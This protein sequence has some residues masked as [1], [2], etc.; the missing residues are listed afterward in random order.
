M[1][2]SITHEENLFANEDCVIQLK[3]LSK[4]RW[5][6]T[7]DCFFQTTIL[8]NYY[9][10]ML[11]TD[12]FVPVMAC[13]AVLLVSNLV[14]FYLQTWPASF[15]VISCQ[16]QLNPAQAVS[17]ISKNAHLQTLLG[18]LRLILPR[19]DWNILIRSAYRRCKACSRTINC[20]K[21]E[22]LPVS[23]QR[24]LIAHC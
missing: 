15:V 7:W 2:S 3:D 20:N 24:W 6:L 13:Y 14:A 18:I 12:A 16:V 11:L 8:K 1:K 5:T 9:W 10:W 19:V 4:A 22:I 17:E 23:P 21:E